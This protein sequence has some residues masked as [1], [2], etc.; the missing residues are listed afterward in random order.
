MRPDGS[1][2]FGLDIKIAYDRHYLR[3]LE[4]IVIS[5]S[6]FIVT[7]L[8]RLVEPHRRHQRCRTFIGGKVIYEKIGEQ[9][10]DAACNS[11]RRIGLWIGLEI[12]HYLHA[13]AEVT[14]NDGINQFVTVE[15]LGYAYVAL[16][17]LG[18]NGGFR[19]STMASFATALWTFDKSA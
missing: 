6:S 11:L 18:G 8:P 5:R 13:F 1:Y 15:I 7:Q 14:R 10:K 3:R 9:G 2:A 12:L 17:G 4:S 16:Y 19:G